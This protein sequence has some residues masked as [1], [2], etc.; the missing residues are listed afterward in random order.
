MLQ[1]NEFETDPCFLQNF[2]SNMTVCLIIHMF[3]K[4]CEPEIVLQECKSKQKQFQVH[5]T[6]KKHE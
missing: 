5:N 6:Y 4:N 3:C 1:L 2:Q